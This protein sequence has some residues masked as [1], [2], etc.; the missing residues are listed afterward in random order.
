MSQDPQAEQQ[1]QVRE[2]LGRDLSAAEIA[3]AGARF[4]TMLRCLRLIRDWSARRTPV[5]MAPVFSV[6]SETARDD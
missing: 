6:P 1:A 2:L 3:V 4:P 5:T